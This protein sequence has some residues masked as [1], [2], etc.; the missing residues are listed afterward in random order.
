MKHLVIGYGEI[1]KAISS[2]LEC[3]AHDSL[4]KVVAEGIYDT[5]HI[6]FPFSENFIEEVRAYREYFGADLVII[7]STVPIGTTETV[8]A[9]AVHSPCRGVHPHLEHGIRTFVKFFGGDRCNAASDIF[10]Q[11]QIPTFCTLHACNTEALK[12]WDTTV[13]GF[14]IILEKEIHRFCEANGLDF[15]VV[16]K[17]SNLSYNSGYEKLKMTHYKKY[18]IEHREGKIGGHCVIPNCNLLDSWIAQ[19]IIDKNEGL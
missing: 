14:N 9:W 8:G 12:L 13:Y 1:G 3:D 2:I 6:C 7:H 11:L 5:L 17:L 18:V 4:Q 10:Q 16:Y 19:L 15:D